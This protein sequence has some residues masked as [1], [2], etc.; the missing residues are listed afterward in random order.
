MNLYSITEGG[1]LPELTYEGFNTAILP[2]N[3][4][5]PALLKYEGVNMVRAT[6][7]DE[8][9]CHSLLMSVPMSNDGATVQFYLIA[10][11]GHPH[12]TATDPMHHHVSAVTA[13]ATAYAAALGVNCFYIVTNR[14]QSSTFSQRLPEWDLVEGPYNVNAKL[15]I[16]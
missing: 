15:E 10:K 5:I 12:L 14:M 13:N 3:Q 11:D 6:Y 1:A 7:D 9:A 16:T 4:N 8:G 2:V